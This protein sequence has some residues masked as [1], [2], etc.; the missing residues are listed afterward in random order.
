MDKEIWKS[1]KK[2]PYFLGNVL[3]EARVVFL[4]DYPLILS[5]LKHRDVDT[6]LNQK[7]KN[8]K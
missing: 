5:L 4:F 2:L 3:V 7:N 8:P 6:F 1:T